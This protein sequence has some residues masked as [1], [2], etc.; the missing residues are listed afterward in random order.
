MEGGQGKGQVLTI[1]DRTE[2]DWIRSVH[3]AVNFVPLKSGIA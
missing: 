1:V 3:E 2:S